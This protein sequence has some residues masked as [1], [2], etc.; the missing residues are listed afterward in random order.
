M[1]NLI[2]P[3]KL[4]SLKRKPVSYETVEEFLVNEPDVSGGYVC[5]VLGIAPSNF[6]SWRVRKG[7]KETSKKAKEN[8][9]PSEVIPTGVGKRKYTPGDMVVLVRDYQKAGEKKRGIFLRT[10]G[11]YHSDLERWR[12]VADQ[13]AIEALGKKKHERVAKSAEQVKIEELEKEIQ[14]QEKV[15]SK[16]SAMIVV[17]KKISS[18]LGIPDPT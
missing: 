4:L 17:Q 1:K 15:I 10:Y 12:A 11:L 16:L 3:E 9:P 14:G 6:Y 2:E 18:I 13:A 7:K 8:L 5:K